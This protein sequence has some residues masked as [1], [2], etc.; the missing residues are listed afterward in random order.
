MKCSNNVITKK[1][2]L[3]NSAIISFYFMLSAPASASTTLQDIMDKGKEV[4][5]SAQGLIIAFGIVAA[6]FCVIAAGVTLKK[7]S[8]GDREAKMSSVVLLLFAALILGGGAYWVSTVG[9]SF[10]VETQTSF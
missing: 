1:I 4:L 6:I 8:D 5:S 9:E 3:L 2:A 7:K 10:G